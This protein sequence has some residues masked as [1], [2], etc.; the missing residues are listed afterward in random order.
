MHQDSQFFRIVAIV[1]GA[2]SVSRNGVYALA[3][4][5]GSEFLVLFY[6]AGSLCNQRSDWCVEPSVMLS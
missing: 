4:H 5:L 1:V 6:L 3:R 2:P